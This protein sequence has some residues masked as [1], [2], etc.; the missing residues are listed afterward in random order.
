MFDGSGS[1]VIIGS[2][3]GQQDFFANDGN[4]QITPK[5][6]VDVVLADAGDD[7]ITL[8]PDGVK[9]TISCGPGNDTVVRVGGI[10]P[11]D[12]FTSCEVFA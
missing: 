8:S 3:A 2:D 11:L 4:D 12:V 9:D 1:S 10:D 5:G 7:T 6:G